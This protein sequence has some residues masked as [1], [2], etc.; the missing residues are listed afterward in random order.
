MWAWYFPHQRIRRWGI[1]KWY[2]FAKCRLSK[3]LWGWWLRGMARSQPLSEGKL[4][5]GNLPI[6]PTSDP[7]TALHW[8]ERQAN[9]TG[10]IGR[11][12]YGFWRGD[13]P[14]QEMMHDTGKY[15]SCLASTNT[16]N[17][18]PKKISPIQS[19]WLVHER[20]PSLANFWHHL[21]L[22][23]FNYRKLL[24]LWL[25]S[26]VLHW[27]FKASCQDAFPEQQFWFLSQ[28][29]GVR[30]LAHSGPDSLVSKELGPHLLKMILPSQR[31]HKGKLVLSMHA[32]K[33]QLFETLG[34]GSYGYLVL[35]RWEN[36]RG[37]SL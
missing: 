1:Q 13:G 18:K 36:L 8:P 19:L 20:V 4:L 14:M 12:A 15:S 3:G 37:D 27:C 26:T 6:R 24:L 2:L 9:A 34:S 10:I 33:R 28:Q 32:G 5:H 21:W 25:K 17:A 22:Q 35:S 29:G 23:R 16:P 11:K 31:I 7:R 30:W